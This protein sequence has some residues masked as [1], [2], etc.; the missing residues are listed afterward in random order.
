VGSTGSDLSRHRLGH[1]RVGTGVA[2]G[3]RDAPVAPGAAGSS[4]E[5]GAPPPQ[6]GGG[7][8]GRG[9]GHRSG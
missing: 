6:R 4:S 1:P 7:A 3:R 8:P 5:D 9:L 2:A